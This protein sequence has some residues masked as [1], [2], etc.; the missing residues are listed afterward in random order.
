MKQV[1]LFLF[2][3]GLAGC[4]KSSD[5]KHPAATALESGTW[6]VT[7]LQLDAVDKTDLFTG[8][9]FTFQGNGTVTGV[10]AGISE[11]G[12][13]AISSAGSGTAAYNQLVLNFAAGSTSSNL[14]Q[15]WDLYG[16]LPNQIQA[17]K[18]FS[19]SG[20]IYVLWLEK[21]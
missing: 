12:T 10:K 15:S 6:R 11:T 19:G 21:N 5:P 4:N 14:N 7:Q 3:A 1:L 20:A 18:N 8:Y 9:V 17:H 16:V 2:I 13:W